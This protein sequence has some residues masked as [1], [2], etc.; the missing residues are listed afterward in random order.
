[1]NVQQR[2]SLITSAETLFLSL[3]QQVNHLID[4]I[5]FFMAR[6]PDESISLAHKHEW[7]NQSLSILAGRMREL[8]DVIWAWKDN[9]PRL[10]TRLGAE[11]NILN[12]LYIAV[13][14]TAAFFIREG[15][16]LHPFN[17]HKFGLAW[18][19]L[20]AINRALP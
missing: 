8:G 3:A 11:I 7:L 5:H 10:I 1:M 13:D 12:E 4:V 17:P 9:S 19:N 20:V 6:Y 2:V 18:G 15:I 14:T 16:D